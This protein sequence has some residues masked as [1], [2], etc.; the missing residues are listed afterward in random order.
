MSCGP[1][2]NN[3]PD[4]RSLRGLASP[5]SPVSPVSPL[6][7]RGEA[8]SNRPH[9][10]RSLRIGSAIS[11]GPVPSSREIGENSLGFSFVRSHIAV[12]DTVDLE[13]EVVA[14]LPVF[15]VSRCGF[16]LLPFHIFI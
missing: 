11:R 13:I 1:T 14:M 9:R 16:L 7:R 12:V 4:Y 10:R 3:D 5:V 15:A 6:R 8:S 2:R